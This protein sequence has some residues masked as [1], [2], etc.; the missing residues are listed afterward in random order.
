PTPA[1]ASNASPSQ[2]TATANWPKPSSRPTRRSTPIFA[3]LFLAPP[4]RG[5][6]GIRSVALQPGAEF[7]QLAMQTEAESSG[8]F[9]VEIGDPSGSTD[10]RS[11]VIRGRSDNGRTTISVRVPAASLKKGMRGVRLLDAGAGSEILDEHVVR[12]ER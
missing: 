9:I 5:G 3:T 10:W 12:I 11:Q 8:R 1:S 2:N 6:S 4:T 7:L